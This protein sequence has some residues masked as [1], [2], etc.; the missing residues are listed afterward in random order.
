MIKYVEDMAF[1]LTE[2]LCA[3][4]NR[5]ISVEFS[6]TLNRPRSFDVFFDLRLNKRLSKQSRRLWFETPSCSSWRRCNESLIRQLD[7]CI[8]QS[9]LCY[10][11]FLVYHM[12]KGPKLKYI[13]WYT[14]YEAFTNMV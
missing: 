1:A 2:P 8:F 13:E 7:H 14:E 10:V 11:S 3:R 12:L 6:Q 9:N 4:F 5:D